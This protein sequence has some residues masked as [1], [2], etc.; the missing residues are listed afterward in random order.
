MLHFIKCWS[1]WLSLYNTQSQFSLSSS[2]ITDDPMEQAFFET[3]MASLCRSA[4]FHGNSI[5]SL[6][7][8]PFQPV[9]F[10]FLCLW[11]RYIYSDPYW[12]S[13]GCSLHCWRIFHYS[14]SCSSPVE[15]RTSTLFLAIV[16][17]RIKLWDKYLFVFLLCG[18]ARIMTRC[19]F[20]N[21]SLFLLPLRR[22]VEF[23]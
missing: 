2:K 8:S 4:G 12:V 7:V 3:I 10:W 20:L 5:D 11:E 13:V 9:G 1:Y 6:W 23:S 16:N 22:L 21:G 19:K 17:N 18:T 15:L 14:S